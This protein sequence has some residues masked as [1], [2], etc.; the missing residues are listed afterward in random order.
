MNIETEKKEIV[1]QL[2]RVNDIRLLK[3]IRNLIEFGLNKDI[4]LEKSIDRGLQQ[5]EK[6]EGREHQE[7]M[8]ELRTR[9]KI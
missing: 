4:D 3:A 9:F 1:Q 7:V 2:E 8:K 5:S 6:G